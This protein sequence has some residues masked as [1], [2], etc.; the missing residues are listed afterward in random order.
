MAAIESSPLPPLGFGGQ[1]TK[2]TE[3]DRAEILAQANDVIDFLLNGPGS[4]TP[5]GP[6]KPEAGPPEYDNTVRDLNNFKASVLTAK[7]FADDPNHVLDSVVD[8]IRDTIDQ[9]NGLAGDPAERDRISRQPPDLNDPIDILPPEDR[10]PTNP[11]SSRAARG[12]PIMLRTPNSIA[13]QGPP[14][15]SAPQGP[16]TGGV[17]PTAFVT[18]NTSNTPQSLFSYLMSTG[19]FAGL[20]HAASAVPSSPRAWQTSPPLQAD[21]TQNPVDNGPTRLLVGRVYDSSNGSP[22]PAWRVPAQESP[23]G[24]LSLNDAYLEYLKRLNGNQSLA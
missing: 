9:V 13:L 22:F 12:Q 7:Q 6:R 10:A 1:I 24:S 18:S 17:P 15:V 14:S 3:A 21:T 20:D 4:F 11:P 23:D 19:N 8:L 5:D 16:V 2:I